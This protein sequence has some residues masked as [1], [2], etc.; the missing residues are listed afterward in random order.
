MVCSQLSIAKGRKYKFKH[1][2]EPKENTQILAI[3]APEYERQY[4]GAEV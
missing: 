3:S 4:R 1:H 2:N